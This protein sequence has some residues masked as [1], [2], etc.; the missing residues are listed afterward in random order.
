MGS[1]PVHKNAKSWIR[2]VGRNSIVD[3]M[4]Y[5]FIPHVRL[6]EKGIEARR[7]LARQSPL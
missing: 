4:C 6:D 3:L 1:A 5:T 2:F 7:L